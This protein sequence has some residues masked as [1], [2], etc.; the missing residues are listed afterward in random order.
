MDNS[1]IIY[2]PRGSVLLFGLN[3]SSRAVQLSRL[4]N[5]YAETDQRVRY[6]AGHVVVL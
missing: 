2:D 1:Q 4:I 5:P 3:S 6:W